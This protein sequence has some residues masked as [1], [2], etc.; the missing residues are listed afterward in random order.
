MIPTTQPVTTP[1]TMEEEELSLLGVDITG[2]IDM[3]DR[4]ECLWLP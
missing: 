4:D 1:A 2:V 3:K